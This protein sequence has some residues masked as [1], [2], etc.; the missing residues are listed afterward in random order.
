MTTSNYPDNPALGAL[1]SDGD[2]T[3]GSTT[4]GGY[5]TT[6]SSS[7]SDSQGGAK[8][9]AKQAAGTAAD[10]AKQTAGTAADQG[11]QVADVAAGEA[12]KVASEA[13]TQVRGL[14]QETTSQLEDQGRTQ[15]DRIVEV[16]RS[17]GDDLE[18]MAASADSGMASNLAH[19]VADRS[20]TLSSHL[21]GREPR[22]LLDD[23]RSFARRKPGVFIVGSLVAGVV[24]GRLARGAKD[25]NDS[26]S[27]GVSS[28]TYAASTPRPGYVSESS[29]RDVDLG[30]PLAAPPVYEVGYPT[31]VQDRP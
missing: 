9:Q 20:R 26:P 4:V 19:E 30:E 1:G 8:E 21:D 12:K 28:P 27:H 24:A 16:L 11:R 23:V 22:E 15:R 5:D 7:T 3:A 18:R 6:V 2:S 10:Q 13:T 25:A 31:T 17:L 29:L 14:L